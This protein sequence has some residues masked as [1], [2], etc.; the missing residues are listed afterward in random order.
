MPQITR[1]YK[2]RLFAFIFGREE[3]KA[4][5]LS[6]Y[7]AVN[8]SHYTDPSA[9]QITTIK[10]VLYLGMHNDVSFI[11][12]NE[13][14][15]YEQQSSY[16][17]NMPVRQF[18]YAAK[19]IERFLEPIKRKLYWKTVVK[20]PAPKLV[21]FYNGTD[22]YPDESILKL[23]D[24]YFEGTKGD[25]EVKVRMLNINVGRNKALF[26][27]CK[28]LQEYSWLVD[29]IRTYSKQMAVEDAVDKTIAEIPD[30]FVLKQLLLEHKA[31]V[32]G[33]I[34][35]E[36]NEEEVMNGFIEEAKEAEKIAFIKNLLSLGVA[37]DI[38]QKA[39]EI[40]LSKFNMIK[41]LIKCEQQ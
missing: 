24:A 21:V 3:N 32:K 5:T 9:I 38:I 14:S 8:G 35:T 2:D 23:S 19:L 34:L 1:E 15:L 22:K 17:P 27:A 7:N 11:I 30:S 28:P 36:Y 20:I 16:N 13:L 37:D 31:E 29:K 26:D 41:S 18:L 12:A 25:I 33:M 39:A 4:W 6:L 40:D 10:E